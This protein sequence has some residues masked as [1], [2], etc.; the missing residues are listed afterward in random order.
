MA[1][2]PHLDLYLVR[3][4]ETDSSRENR[5]SGESDI[6]LNARGEAMA[7]A[8]ADYYARER[9]AA[10][11][12]S[13]LR[14]AL[15]TAKP[16]AERVRIAVRVEAALHEIRYG[17]WDGTLETA[18][19]ERYPSAFAAWRADPGRNAPPGGETGLAILARALPAI[20]AIRQRHGS[21]KV[22]VVSHKATIRV[23]ICALLGLDVGLF[24]TRIAQPVSAVNIFRFRPEGPLLKLLGD[25][26]HLPPDLRAEMGT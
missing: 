4:G 21:G 13:P 1:E 8:L 7:R 25:I 26:C 12:S 2:S 9:W 22:M 18:A 10:I 20:D 16:L 19:E 5:F 6:P 23:L 15:E 24:R 3:H 11:Y 17:L 14:R